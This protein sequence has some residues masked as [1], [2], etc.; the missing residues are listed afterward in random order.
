VLYY[1]GTDFRWYEGDF[2]AGQFDGHG[3]LFKAPPDNDVRNPSKMNKE[4]PLYIGGF[5]RDEKEGHGVEND[6]DEPK[7]QIY[8]GNFKEGRRHGYGVSEPAPGH[9]YEGN[10][11]ANMMHGAGTYHILTSGEKYEGMFVE[12]LRHGHGSYYAKDGLRK[13]ALWEGGEQ[14]PTKEV[15]RAR[16]THTHTYH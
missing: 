2:V 14:T 5:K 8:D 16:A 4:Y 10:F 15:S 1:E 3:V 6:P 11:E 13:D 12:N 9:K 7:R